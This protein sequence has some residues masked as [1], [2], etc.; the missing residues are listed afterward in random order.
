MYGHFKASILLSQHPLSCFFFFTLFLMLY[1]YFPYAD[2]SLSSLSFSP[3]P[4]SLSPLTC[5]VFSS[6]IYLHSPTAVQFHLFSP[7]SCSSLNASVAAIIPV[8]SSVIRG[9]CKNRCMYHWEISDNT[10]QVK[11]SIICHC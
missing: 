5:P 2:P 4:L 10:L 6:T 11:H 9:Q 7:V 1:P 8:S 3:P